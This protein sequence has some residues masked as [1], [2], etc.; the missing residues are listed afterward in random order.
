VE[1]WAVACV[2]LIAVMQCPQGNDEE[3]ILSYQI[4]VKSAMMNQSSYDINKP[5]SSEE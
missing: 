2:K 1:V 3:K 5:C 4:L